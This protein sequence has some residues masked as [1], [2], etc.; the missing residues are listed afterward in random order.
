MYDEMTDE[1][2]IDE[3]GFFVFCICMVNSD[4][5]P[6]FALSATLTNPVGVYSVTSDKNENGQEIFCYEFYAASFS[7]FM[8]RLVTNDG[9]PDINPTLGEFRL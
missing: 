5:F 7:E 9:T 2:I 1:L 6:T 8:A 4:K 3:Q